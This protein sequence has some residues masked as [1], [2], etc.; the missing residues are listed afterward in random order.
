MRLE[1]DSK[2]PRLEQLK[3]VSDHK[4]PGRKHQHKPSNR[5][6]Q[7]KANS[8]KRAEKAKLRAMKRKSDEIRAYWRGERDTNPAAATEPQQSRDSLN[9]GDHP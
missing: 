6:V 2:T 3:A 8:R 5:A 4:Q 1:F 9:L 7:R